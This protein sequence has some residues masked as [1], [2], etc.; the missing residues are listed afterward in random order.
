MPITYLLRQSFPEGTVDLRW[1]DSSRREVRAVEAAIEATWR[2]WKRKPGI[3]LFDG[4]IARLEGWDV[5]EG[6]GEGQ[7]QGRLKLAVSRTSYRL[8]LGTNLI[9]PHLL[10]QYGNEVGSNPIGVSTL[11]R[12]ADGHLVLGL[13]NDRVAFY[14]R[15]LHPFAGSLEVRDDVD[16]FADARREL[17][18]ELGLLPDEVHDLRLTGIAMDTR[19]SQPEMILA[20]DTTRTLN[21]VVA[22]LDAEE[23]TAHWSCP[24]TPEAARSA[25]ET[26]P[27]LT[28]VA[29]A[30]LTLWADTAK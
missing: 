1:V 14:P 23:H 12:T 7:G 8:F 17:H 3:T 21:E 20:A 24:A 26:E 22:G 25:V 9:N 5:G 4:P 15:R 28:P 6:Q 19:L 16:V 11:L 2:D 30:A 18:E 27:L 10:Q 29:T 13:R